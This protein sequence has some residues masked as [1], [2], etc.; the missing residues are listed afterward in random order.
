MKVCVYKG[1][2]IMNRKSVLYKKFKYAKLS[3]VRSFVVIFEERIKR[4]I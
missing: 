3:K 2:K 1:E 4:F